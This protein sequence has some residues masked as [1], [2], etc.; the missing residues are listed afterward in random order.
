MMHGMP[1]CLHA[2]NM[3]TS[4]AHVHAHTS[5]CSTVHAHNVNAHTA[6]STAHYILRLTFPFFICVE[7]WD[8]YG[9]NEGNL[10]AELFPP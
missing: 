10:K 6:P 1:T 9:H 2:A 7:L 3:Q 5:T 4:Q 8:K